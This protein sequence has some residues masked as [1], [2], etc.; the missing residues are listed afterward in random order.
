M[1]N[2]ENILRVADA[3]EK[4]EIPWL[5]FNMGDW[6][7]RIN[8]TD[9]SNHGCK[10]VACIG[11]WANVLQIST[12]EDDYSR[13]KS[14]PESIWDTELAREWLGLSEEQAKALFYP[15]GYIDPLIYSLPRAVAALR[16]LVATGEVNW[17]L[18]LQEPAK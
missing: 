6:F 7:N 11:G 18:E 4:H 10:T 15:A 13:E 3:I 16:H 5:G 9:Y 8:G 1:V 2:V 12:A 14:L 17:N